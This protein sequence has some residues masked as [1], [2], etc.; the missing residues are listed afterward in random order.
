MQNLWITVLFIS[1]ILLIWKM[2]QRVCHLFPFFRIFQSPNNCLASKLKCQAPFAKTLQ[3]LLNYENS[4]HTNTRLKRRSQSI[5]HMCILS[6]LMSLKKI[7]QTPPP[8]NMII[9]WYKSSNFIQ[10]GFQL[11]CFCVFLKHGGRSGST[12][13]N[14]QRIFAPKP[15]AYL[16]VQTRK[17]N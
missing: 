16:S 1:Y 11:V 14:A 17:E 8:Q 15:C 5:G 13:M 6:L 2:T 12:I 3:S 7:K 9:K 4:F 10:E